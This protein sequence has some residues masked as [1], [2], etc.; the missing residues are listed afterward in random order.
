MQ[1]ISSQILYEDNH[2]LV[3][4]KP[5]GVLSQGDHT[6][7]ET[8]LDSGKAYI[9][10]KYD[11]PGAVFLHP[12]SRLDRP[13]SGAIILARTSKA[14]TRMN[15]LVKNRNIKKSYRAIVDG[16]PQNTESTL[17]HYLAKDSKTNTVKKVK[18]NHPKAKEAVLDYQLIHTLDKVSILH[19]NLR[20]GRPHQIRVQLS[21]IGHPIVGDGKYGYRSTEKLNYIYLHCRELQ[22]EHPIKKEPV[23]ITAAYPNFPLW[24]ALKSS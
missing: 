5:N 22:F 15:E 13:V 16:I 9:K 23:L 20:T 7:N 10:K 2:L 18:K 11:K 6:G 4:N 17:R 21:T 19:V 1:L 12:V 3:V 14:L 24:K 8:I